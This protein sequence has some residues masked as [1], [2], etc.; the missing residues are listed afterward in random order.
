MHFERSGYDVYV[1]DILNVV[2]LSADRKW[3]LNNLSY[4]DQW[5]L[6][7]TV[8]GGSVV[9]QMNDETVHV[10]KNS[11]LFFPVNFERSAICNSD[12]TARFI[13]I[14]FR[15]RTANRQTDEILNSIPNHIIST[16]TSMQKM[17]EMIGDIWN[18]KRPG[19]VIRCKGLVYNLLYELLDQSVLMEE[20][21]QLESKLHPT[22][23]VIESNVDRNYTVQELANLTRLSPSYF[24]NIFKQY[25]GYTPN[26]Y[27]NYIKV[28]RA[29]DLLLSGHY[30]VSEVAAMLGYNDTSY[31]C[32]IFKKVIGVTPTQVVK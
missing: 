11:I 14:K 24:Q 21:H 32:R 16:S 15:M 1:D 18:R 28:G 9:Y 5:V 27:Q 26:Q 6:S 23:E 30:T 4:A 8:S 31:F 22:M 13:V 10:K 12:E 3:R 25:T 7:Y 29:R 17:F 2:N 19:Y 20:R